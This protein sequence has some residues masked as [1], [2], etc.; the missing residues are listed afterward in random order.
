MTTIR[1]WDLRQKSR[2]LL[3]KIKSVLGSLIPSSGK[4]I[5]TDIARLWKQGRASRNVPEG[6]MTVEQKLRRSMRSKLL[7]AGVALVLAV[8]MVFTMTAAWYTNVIQT[9]GLMF[10][11]SEWGLDTNVNIDE[12]LI[13]AAPGEQG[14]LDLTVYNSSEGLIDVTLNISKASLYNDLADMRKRLYFYID[15]TVTRNEESVQRVYVNSQETYTYTVLPKQNL[16][17]GAQ[18]NDAPLA[19]E[20]VYDVL[21]YYFSGTVTTQSAQIAEYLRPISYDFDSATFADGK[22]STVDGETSVTAFITELSKTDG[23]AG[24]VT[25]SVKTA[26]GRVYYPVSVDGDGTG[27]WMYCCDLA[28]INAENIVDTNLGNTAE[29]AGRWFSTQLNVLAEQKKLTVATVNSDEELRT[30]LAD[31]THN[32]VVLSSN[33]EVNE[34]IRVTGGNEKILDL[35]EYTLSTRLTDNMLAVEEGASVTVM[36]G[37]VR[38]SSE[39][40]GALISAVGS[41]VALSGLTVTDVMD[42]VWIADQTAKENDSR[43]TITDC[44]I[45]CHDSGV[46]IKGNGTVTEK[47][48]YLHIENTEIYSDGNYGVVGNGAVLPAGNFGTD[49]TIRNSKLDALY[50][51]IYHPQPESYLLVENCTIKGLTPIVIKGGTATIHDTN[52]E[53]YNGAQFESMI[54][55]PTLA[56]SGF[57]NTGAGLYVETGYDYICAV[58]VSGNTRITSHYNDAVLMYKEDNSRYSVSVTGGSYSHDVSAFTA[59][60]YSCTGGDDGRYTVTE[61]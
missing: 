53:A 13:N 46:F 59:E 3:R 1:R 8:A 55:Q 14:L 47:R 17:L 25:T 12:E 7:L 10:N 39:H 38:G 36:N 52:V 48:T 31:D 49:I 33:I 37:T 29:Q 60:G 34:S 11:V 18:G 19:W 54:E 41:D 56:K 20:W 45:R 6:E 35:S 58:T 28:E 42:A 2:R 32:M 21:G 22:L 50:A 9:T 4:K 44:V 5:L 27:V 26:D 30:A 40:S 43:V 51:G 16:Q 57:S 24:T 23:F 15:D 61:N